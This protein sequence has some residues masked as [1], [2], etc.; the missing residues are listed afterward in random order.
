MFYWG[1]SGFDAGAE[2]QGAC[3][4]ARGPRK[5]GQTVVGNDYALA[6]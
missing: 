4:G 6:A 1:R 5:N 3:R 2:G